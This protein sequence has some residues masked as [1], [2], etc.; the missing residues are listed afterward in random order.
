[1]NMHTRLHAENGFTLVELLIGFAVMAVL[2]VLAAPSFTS[3]IEMQRLRG[4][5][6]QLTTDIQFMRTEAASR[7]EVTGI[8][9]AEDASMTCYVVHTCGTVSGEDCFCDCRQSTPETRCLA[10]RREV[11]LVQVPRSSKV[12]VKSIQVGAAALTSTHVVID[13]STG[14]MQIYY[15]VPLTPT[16]TPTVAE[17]WAETSLSPTASTV[18]SLQT[19]INMM[20]RPNVCAPG[21]VVKGPTP[22][23]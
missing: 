15:P 18:G 12:A 6:D 11:K 8:S 21:G 17:F 22:C 13:P 20:G 7:Q 23:P 19:R 4:T 1:M 10:P 2:L 5:H 14:A 16:P 3:M 9:F